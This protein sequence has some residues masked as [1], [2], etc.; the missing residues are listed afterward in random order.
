M[1]GLIN[2]LTYN[3]FIINWDEEFNMK[4]T[5]RIEDY[6]KIITQCLT[7][8]KELRESNQEK[9]L[10][11]RGRK[12]SPQKGKLNKNNNHQRSFS[13]NLNNNE[14]KTNFNNNYDVLDNKN[15]PAEN[16]TADK[17]IEI[18]RVMINKQDMEI[19]NLKESNK[20]LCTFVEKNQEIMVSNYKSEL[21]ALSTSIN[22]MRDFYEDELIKRNEIIDNLSINIEDILLNRQ[23]IGQGGL[24]ALGTQGLATQG[25]LLTQQT[26]G[27]TGGANI[28]YETQTNLTPTNKDLNN[29]F[30]S[31]KQ[32]ILQ[33]RS[34]TI[35]FPKFLDSFIS[36]SGCATKKLDYIKLELSDIKGSNDI[37]VNFGSGLNSHNPGKSPINRKF[38]K[39]FVGDHNHDLDEY[40]E[41]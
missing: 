11:L 30:I 26:Q 24:G 25:Q 3:N 15:K 22:I 27:K 18:C 1:F 21:E 19:F 23:S 17:E 39:S 5:E 8:I 35:S 12:N 40:D 4:K 14:S 38:I 2:M 20:S 32:K 31:Q 28:T 37:K 29:Y 10:A 13:S 34:E 33:S 36:E 41:E 16:W 9:E 6:E 7:L